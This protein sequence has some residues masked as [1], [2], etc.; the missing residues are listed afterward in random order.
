MRVRPGFQRRGIGS[1]ILRRL[2]QRAAELGFRR[3]ELWTTPQ[4]APARKLYERF[5]YVE[6]HR[7][8]LYGF[9]AIHYAKELG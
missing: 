7:Q 6:T 4:Q 5:G 1:A 8:E 9:E 3:L 2:E